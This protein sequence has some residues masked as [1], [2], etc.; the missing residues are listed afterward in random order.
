GRARRGGHGRHLC[1]FIRLGGG[2]RRDDAPAGRTA[3]E[4]AL[5]RAGARAG[6]AAA[7][8]RAQ[9]VRAR[10]LAGAV[11]D[12]AGDAGVADRRESF[13]GRVL[14]PQ[15]P[16]RLPWAP[17]AVERGMTTEPR[18]TVEPAVARII[19]RG[20][21]AHPDVVPDGLVALVAA[22]VDAVGASDDPDARAADVYLAAAC[23]L[24]Q[25]AAT[26]RR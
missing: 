4:V 16:A 9:I 19:A 3:I 7:A 25:P 6:D 8:E 11:A 12:E 10:A 14:V 17:E 1:E 5:D 2:Q 13:R 15:R 21:R 18:Q 24:G 23:T 26:A 20:Q 22:R